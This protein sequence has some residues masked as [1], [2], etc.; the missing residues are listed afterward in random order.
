MPFIARDHSLRHIKYNEYTSVCYI[1]AIFLLL[2]TKGFTNNLS[3]YKPAWKI[4]IFTISLRQVWNN[5]SSTTGFRCHTK[6]YNAVHQENSTSLWIWSDA[7][8]SSCV[9]ALENNSGEKWVSVITKKGCKHI[10]YPPAEAITRTQYM[11]FLRSCFAMTEI[12]FK[13]MVFGQSLNQ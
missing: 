2:W 4:P 11:H 13:K 8:H 9:V 12:L 3:I 6:H 1:I 10:H 5:C 7:C